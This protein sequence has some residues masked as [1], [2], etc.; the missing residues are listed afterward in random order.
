MGHERLLTQHEH[1]TPASEFSLQS[2]TFDLLFC[3][4]GFDLSDRERDGERCELP[5]AEGSA[6]HSGEG[7]NG[8]TGPDGGVQQGA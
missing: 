5:A 6:R 4:G 8:Q 3:S 1:T 2:L 7:D